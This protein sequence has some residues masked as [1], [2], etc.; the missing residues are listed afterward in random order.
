MNA[1]NLR[2][3][4]AALV[5]I[6]AATSIASPA[7]AAGDG[8]LHATVDPTGEHITCGSTDLVITGGTLA[9]TW[10]TSQDSN[11][12]Y[13]LGGTNVPHGVTLGDTDG[14]T[15]ELVGASHFTGRSSTPDPD[16][17][18]SATDVDH[19]VIRTPQGAPLGQVQLVV[20]LTPR[21]GFVSVDRGTCHL[22]E[23]D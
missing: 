10:H 1:M 17:P 11:G 19:F 8:T 16:A 6:A 12:I 21:R 9:M 13:H 22:V 23:S 5:T 14:N 4:L 20:H 2:R 18:I 3:G 15:Y 7:L